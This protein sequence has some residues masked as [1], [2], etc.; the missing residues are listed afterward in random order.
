M[1]P[2]LLA[3]VVSSLSK[4][5]SLYRVNLVIAEEAAGKGLAWD[6]A[7]NLGAAYGSGLDTGGKGKRWAMMSVHCFSAT[8]PFLSLSIRLVCLPCCLL[9]TFIVRIIVSLLGKGDP[10][11][12]LIPVSLLKISF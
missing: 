8:P 11:F 3:A 5:E 1:S 7:V 10:F 12:G 6:W 4:W 9:M 2:T